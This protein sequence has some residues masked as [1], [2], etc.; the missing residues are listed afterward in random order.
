MRRRYDESG[1]PLTRFA[2]VYPWRWW[3]GRV[4]CH[5]MMVCR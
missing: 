1:P 2:A 4:G 5:P 3:C